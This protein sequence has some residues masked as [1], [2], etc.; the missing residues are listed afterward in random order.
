MSPSDRRH[1]GCFRKSRNHG[2][3]NPHLTRIREFQQSLIT[4]PLGLPQPA[5]SRDICWH[6]NLIGRVKSCRTG[7]STLRQACSRASC[8]RGLVESAVLMSGQGTG[9]CPPRSSNTGRAKLYLLRESEC[10]VSSQ[11]SDVVRC[12]DVS[13]ARRTLDPFRTGSR[14]GRSTVLLTFCVR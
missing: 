13:D 12:L 11:W 5:G 2:A 4:A 14:E 8:F 1:R 6:N 10:T 3:R 9:G 7:R